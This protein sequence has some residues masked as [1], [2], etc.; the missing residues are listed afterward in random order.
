MSEDALNI[1]N[2]KFYIKNIKFFDS[3]SDSIDL[4]FSSGSM[5]EAKFSNIGNDA[6]DLSGSNVNLTNVNFDKVADKI[7]SVGENSKIKISNINA[8]QSYVGIASKDGSVVNASNINMKNVKLPFLSFN[9]KFE[10]EPANMYLNNINITE[11]EQKWLTD[12]LSKIYHNNSQV[13]KLSKNIIPIVYDKN[14]ELLQ[15]IN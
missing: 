14:L 9:K 3:K 7:I 13:G 11:Y 8:Q 6:I 5:D 2:S 4:D 12:K 15:K 10:Y 1:V